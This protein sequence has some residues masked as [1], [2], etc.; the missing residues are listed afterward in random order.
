MLKMNRVVL[1][2]AVVITGLSSCGNQVEEELKLAMMR[3]QAGHGKYAPNLVLLDKAWDYRDKDG[4][5]QLQ[6][7][8][9]ERDYFYAALQ[10]LKQGSDDYHWFERAMHGGLR[11]SGDLFSMMVS[12]HLS[13]P[14]ASPNSDQ[15]LLALKAYSVA[16]SSSSIS[17]GRGS[18][19]SGP[20]AEAFHV[21]LP[22]QTVWED[23]LKHIY[24]QLKSGILFCELEIPPPSFFKN[25]DL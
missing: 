20:L 6:H 22:Y 15:N 13:C 7:F 18:L 2:L 4:R 21:L 14:A 17:L 23:A 19:G 24:D 3:E 8:F 5:R 11:R 25:E 9:K 16:S 1:L 12:V 10:E